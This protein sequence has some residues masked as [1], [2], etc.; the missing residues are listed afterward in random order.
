MGRKDEVT[1]RSKSST[2]IRRERGYT[3]NIKSWNC[4][5]WGHVSPQCDKLVRMGGDMYPI[6]HMENE[7]SRD[8]ALV[9]LVDHRQAIHMACTC[10]VPG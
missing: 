8:Y 6:M 5:E 1:P 10:G 9:T 4:G 3:S 2:S 7:R